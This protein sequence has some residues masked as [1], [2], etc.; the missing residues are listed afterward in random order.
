MNVDIEYCIKRG[1]ARRNPQP[2]I[3]VDFIKRQLR[4]RDY[5]AR[6]Y[7]SR[8]PEPAKGEVR[9]KEFVASEAERLG[10]KEST[11]YHRYYRGGYPNLK[12]RR[13]NHSV[14]FVKVK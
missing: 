4:N 8:V 5:R 12:M 6:T 9:F 10:E 3:N 14:V 2:I 11:I 7:K 13:V 1:W